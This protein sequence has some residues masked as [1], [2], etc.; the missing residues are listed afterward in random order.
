LEYN[1]VYLSE[2]PWPSKAYYDAY[3]RARERDAALFLNYGYTLPKVFSRGPIDQRA[4]A[5]GVEGPRWIQSPEAIPRGEPTPA[6][7]P[8]PTPARPAAARMFNP[9]PA[10]RRIPAEAGPQFDWGELGLS[11]RPSQTADDRVSAASY[12]TSPSG[13]ERL[14]SNP[15]ARNHRPVAAGPR[16]Q[17]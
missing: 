15:A 1:N 12:R 11:P 4:G 5:E 2:G 16:A 7:E 6:K 17:R 9:P 8:L 3:G 14:A 13:H 10:A